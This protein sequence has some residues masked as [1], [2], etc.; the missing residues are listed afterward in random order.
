MQMHQRGQDERWMMRWGAILA[1]PATL[2]S[3]F[4]LVTSGFLDSRVSGMLFA[5]LVVVWIPTPIG[6]VLLLVGLGEFVSNGG[7][8]RLSWPNCT[9]CGYLLHGLPIHRCPECG[10]PFE[11]PHTKTRK[12]GR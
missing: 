12:R 2:L 8:R 11:P 9:V 10:T 6:A 3:A 5:A 7:R 1:L 4:L